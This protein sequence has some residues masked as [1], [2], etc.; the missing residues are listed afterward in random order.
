MIEQALEK[1]PEIKLSDIAEMIKTKTGKKVQ[2]GIIENVAKQMNGI[3]I[4]KIGKAKGVKRT[5][6]TLFNGQ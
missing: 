2:N 5:T 1:Q 6:R 4:I 3:E